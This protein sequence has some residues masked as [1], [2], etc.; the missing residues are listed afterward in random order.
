MKV[1]VQITLER[2]D[3]TGIVVEDVFTLER[4]ALAPDTLGLQLHEA[5][6]LLCAVQRAVVEE[7]ARGALA[8][9]VA[10]PGCDAPRRHKDAREIVVRSLFGTLRLPSPRWLHCPCSAHEART[11]SPL[12]A[13]IPERTTPE[14]RYLAAKFAGLVSYGLSAR[15]LAEILPLGRPLHATAVRLH[16]QAVAQR[17]EVE[18]G[19][20]QWSFIDG[21]PATWQDLPRP[22]LPLVVAIDGGY[23][24][25]SE[26][27][28]RRDGWF[29]VIAGRSTPDQGPAKTFAF[30]QTHDT[31]PKR[32]LYD[33]LAAQGMQANQHVTFITDGGEDIRELPLYLNPNAEHLLDWFHITMRITVMAN[34]AKGLRS[35]PPDPDSPPGP[36]IDL[37]A[38]AGEELQRV[39]RFLWHGNAF[40]AQQ[41]LDDLIADLD[42]DEQDARREHRKLLKALRE[43]ATYIRGNETSI[44]NYGERHRAG[45]AISSSLAESAINQ[46]VSK[47]MVKKQQMRWSPRGAHLLLQIRTR[48]LNDDLANDFHRWYP[49]F[50]HTPPQENIA[51]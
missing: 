2:D 12:A 28:S 5:K 43:F 37:A 20:E 22:D 30:V 31:K 8:E 3:E 51:A 38:R 6:D 18:L 23:V 42:T 25:S 15:L 46:V 29:E 9:Q 4:R 13:V 32:R 40:R 45:E 24:H 11:F 26:Q 19:D 10:C 48:V 1:T 7:Q 39:K 17:L 16:T 44:P 47:R 36:P 33:V 27:R 21:C 41:V 50:T 49:S 14:L 35:P 34:T